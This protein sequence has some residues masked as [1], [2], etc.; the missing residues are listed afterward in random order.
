MS[1]FRD[2]IK[3]LLPFSFW[4]KKEVNAAENLSHT[5]G[6][7]NDACI[8]LSFLIPA[9]IKKDDHG[10]KDHLLAIRRKWLGE[11]RKLKEEILSAIQNLKPGM[12]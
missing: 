10:E 9:D 1:I 5:L 3:T 12:P 7:F 2:D 6:L 11:K 8:A 4:N